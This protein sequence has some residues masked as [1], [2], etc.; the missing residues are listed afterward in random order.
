MSF[1]CLPLF[2]VLAATLPA[3]SLSTLPASHGATEGTGFTNIPFGRSTPVRVQYAYDAMLFSGPHTITA[4][5]FRLDGDAAAAGKVVDC[6]IRMSTMPVTL[7]QMSPT[8]AVNRGSDETVVLPRQLLTLP[9]ANASGTPS[10]FL[11]AI[12]LA[13]PFTH[14]PANGGLVIEIVVHG[15]PPGAYSLD[16]TYVCDSPESAIGP[17]SCAQSSGL[18]LRVESAT[19]QVIWGRPW[20]A[21]VL[22]VPAG[23]PVVLIAGSQESGPWGGFVLPQDLGMF[24]AAGCYLSID[25]ASSW[26]GVAGPDGTLTFPFVLANSPSTIGDWLRYQAAVFDPTAN[27]L[28]LVTSQARKVQVCGWEPVAR[29]WASNVTSSIGTREIG[30]SAVV[31]ITVQ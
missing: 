16:V 29:V 4:L 31:Q 26:F 23:A 6:E 27:A 20:I 5:Q 3:Q 10:T 11:P 2:F 25:A 18:P 7:V 17:M 24:G 13:V 19:T 8:F 22:D 1:R 30:V 14:D 9:G 21:R 28:G 15:Q 12:P